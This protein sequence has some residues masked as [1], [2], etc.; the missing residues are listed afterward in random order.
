MLKFA[1]ARSVADAASTP[2]KCAFCAGRT[3]NGNYC[4]TVF[5]IRSS[6]ALAGFLPSGSARTHVQQQASSS[7]AAIPARHTLLHANIQCSSA[8][9][10]SHHS[11]IF[12]ATVLGQI[13]PKTNLFFFLFC[14]QLGLKL[15]W[16][17]SGKRK[18]E[19]HCSQVIA[20]ATQTD[21]LTLTL[22]DN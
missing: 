7:T 22:T 16:S 21:K 18:E 9:P 12:V 4:P 19:T 17:V 11:G 2:A 3:A 8:G 20:E 13:K 10:P 6:C 15:E 5:N 1:V 14:F